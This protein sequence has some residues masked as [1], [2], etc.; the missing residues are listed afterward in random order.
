MPPCFEDFS[1]LS[2]CSI[3]ELTSKKEQAKQGTDSS[4]LGSMLKIE[5][6]RFESQR[7]S[8]QLMTKEVLID[9][10]ESDVRCRKSV[11]SKYTFIRRFVGQNKLDFVQ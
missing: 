5:S 6:S 3:D 4:S 11:I 2:I 7:P 8:N 9:I 1:P 10:C